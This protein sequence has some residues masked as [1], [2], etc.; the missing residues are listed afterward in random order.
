VRLIPRDRQFYELFNEI[1]GRVVASATVL[2]ELFHDPSQISRYVAEIKVI[3]HEADV[4]TRD[5]IVRIDKS[6]VTPFDREDIYLLASRL[7]DVID[8]LDGTARRAEMFHI[9]EVREPAKQLTAVLMRAAA[10]IASAVAE[11]RRPN[12]VLKRSL[13]IKQL[14]EE[15]DAIYHDAV[16]GLFT[17][18]ADPLEVIK[19]KELYDTLE[20]AIDQCEDVSNVLESISLKNG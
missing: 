16:G 2:N 10:S 13:E 12:L 14:E 17:G 8:L 7:D 5:V 6:F 19:W 3:E 1:A 15:A 4:L 20:R 11:M 18:S 9:H